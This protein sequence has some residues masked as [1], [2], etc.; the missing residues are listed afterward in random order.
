MSRHSASDNLIVCTKSCRAACC[1]FVTL[2]EALEGAEERKAVTFKRVRQNACI[3]M[4][5]DRTYAIERTERGWEIHVEVHNGP[6]PEP[7]ITYHYN[8]T[9]CDF[10][11]AQPAEEVRTEEIRVEE[12]G[13]KAVVPLIRE[14]YE[15][16]YGT[17]WTPQLQLSEEA[18][19]IRAETFWR[20]AKDLSASAML[21]IIGQELVMRMKVKDD[22][23]CFTG[24]KF[25]FDNDSVQLYFKRRKR[26]LYQFLVLPQT[27]EG[28]ACVLEGPELA[29]NSVIGVSG[30]VTK[31]GYELLISI[32]FA[33][34]GGTPEDG[35][36]VGFDLVI[37]DRDK[38]VRRDK[39]MIWS[40]ARKGER[41]YLKEI[42]HPDE[43]YGILRFGCP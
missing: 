39:Q 41:T 21:C 27:N 33:M 26:D 25:L 4:T 3:L 30:K 40:G 15:A 31:D 6:K 11:K 35:E 17:A 13:K 23:P 42:K 38:G 32:P 22:T 29:Q 34:I 20:G 12:K 18:Q 9:T 36:E 28:C 14:S 10:D 8:D 43:C 1:H 16:L 2:L 24:G 7:V 19:I 37:N 5:K